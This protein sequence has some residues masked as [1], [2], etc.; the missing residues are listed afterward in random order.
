MSNTNTE[1]L[2][3]LFEGKLTFLSEKEQQEYFQKL[4]ELDQVYEQKK[5]TFSADDKQTW[6]DV[7]STA[8]DLSDWCDEINANPDKI[9]ESKKTMAETTLNI[10]LQAVRQ[11]LGLDHQNAFDML[12]D[13]LGE[14]FKQALNEDE[15]FTGKGK[16]PAARL[17]E[18]LST[19]QV[20]GSDAEE[21]AKCLQE[22]LPDCVTHVEPFKGLV[23]VFERFPSQ[24]WL[25]QAL[26]HLSPAAQNVIQDFDQALKDHPRPLLFE[27]QY[28]D[29]HN[30]WMSDLDVKTDEWALALKK[31]SRRSPRP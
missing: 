9:H 19:N 28:E 24:N 4:E 27:S 10:V 11:P 5:D 22:I 23:E 21:V 8:T 30:D 31:E 20:T 2:K 29:K 15:S 18:L 14:A 13:G 7:I 17:V 1:S 16:A 26:P 6:K 3:D 25:P 12:F